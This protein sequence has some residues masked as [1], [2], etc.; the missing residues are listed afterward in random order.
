[1]NAF[2]FTL[3]TNLIGY[4]DYDADR[5]CE[6]ERSHGY[7]ED[8]DGYECDHDYN[9]C[10]VVE[11][12]E[13]NSIDHDRLVRD[14]IPD[15][16]PLA[17][18]ILDRY[19]RREL[20]GNTYF[21]FEADRGYYGEYVSEITVDIDLHSLN[22]CVDVTNQFQLVL[23]NEYQHLL[24][25]LEKVEEWKVIEVS[26]WD[27]IPTSNKID[28]GIVESY[29]GRD[30]VFPVGIALPCGAGKYQLFDGHHRFEAAKRDGRDT[31]KVVVPA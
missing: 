28:K 14:A 15:Q 4:V 25:N 26:V 27:L 11:S 13:V 30:E 6:R 31:V 7:D 16:N 8:D 1:M 19:L 10:R 23:F 20:N 21:S 22:Y 9:R 2:N 17:L 29:K 24:P 5:V 18:Y 12:V 3:P